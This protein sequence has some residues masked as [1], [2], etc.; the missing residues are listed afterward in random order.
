[1]HRFVNFLKVLAVNHPDRAM[2]VF[3][4]L[5][6]WPSLALWG[7]RFWD[8]WTLY[9]VPLADQVTNFSQA[10]VPWIGFLYGFL[11]S[12][13][14]S[15]GILAFICPLLALM[16]WRQVLEKI[17][18][19]TKISAF[20]GILLASV[21]PVFIARFSWIQLA[22]ILGL[23]VFVNAWFGMVR[24]YL[25]RSLYL[26]PLPAAALLLSFAL[27]PAYLVLSIGIV[28]HVLW[29]ESLSP[30]KEGRSPAILIAV[31]VI[32]AISGWF[33]IRS[34]FF[35]P[36]GT[37]EGYNQ[38]RISVAL[39]VTA[40][41]TI[42][43]FFAFFSSVRGF[44]KL[45]VR[46]AP[47]LAPL[48][49]SAFVF[50]LAIGP[51]VAIGSSPPYSEWQT[52]Y[53]INGLL[54]LALAAASLIAL[55]SGRGGQLLKSAI[56]ACMG[57]A[58]IIASNIAGLEALADWKKQKSIIGG[59]QTISS[60]LNETLV[61]FIDDTRDQSLFERQYRFYEWAGILSE[62]TGR[63]TSFGIGADSERGAAQTV[64][65]YLESGHPGLSAVYNHAW[66]QYEPDESWR[67]I[68]ISRGPHSCLALFLN[69]TCVQVELLG[70]S[71]KDRSSN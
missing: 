19:L 63:T 47:G 58:M 8:D 38:I 18:G 71:I 62:S 11:V 54:F 32:A 42:S 53:E 25:D 12:W 22:S 15:F 26:F 46:P 43:V 37:Y 24:V 56:A 6:W 17:P 27:Y 50:A 31:T 14:P 55:I 29:L 16:V 66:A 39:I 21:A 35:E 34:I 10:G 70:S 52:R 33:L 41:L 59:L 28:V 7:G 5:S 45:N 4:T 23:L 2:A 67:I 40:V 9:G 57:L 44:R 69:D 51:Y 61:V 68:K 1:M 60:E 13:P 30:R 3:Y 20:S 49:F 64:E 48:F 65:Q 36:S